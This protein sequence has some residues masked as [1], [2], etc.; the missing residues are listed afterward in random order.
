MASTDLQNAI[1]ARDAQKMLVVSMMAMLKKARADLKECNEAVKTAREAAKLEKRKLAGG[2]A[3]ASKS[4]Q[5]ASPSAKKKKKT[6]KN[7]NFKRP[8]GGAP[9]SKTHDGMRMVWDYDNGGW[10]EPVVGGASV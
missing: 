8:R 1:N 2:G 9:K 6:P 4:S 10:K 7:P 3:P 5:K